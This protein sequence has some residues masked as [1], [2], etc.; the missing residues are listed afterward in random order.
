MGKDLKSE[1]TNPFYQK[2]NNAIHA[3]TRAEEEGCFKELKATA[4]KKCDDVIQDFVQCSKDHT[5]TVIFSC[6][7]KSRVMNKCLN[8]YTT[9]EELDKL[10]LTKI[11]AK[12]NAR[13]SA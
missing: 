13:N 9:Q 8:S 3:L 4:L 6:R 1:M 2:Q 5:V 7:G 12:A 10:K 11:A